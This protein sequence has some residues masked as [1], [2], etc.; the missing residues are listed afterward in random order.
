MSLVRFHS[1]HSPEASHLLR[2]AAVAA[3]VTGATVATVALVVNE[4]GKALERASD[5]N[6]TAIS[7]PLG[8]I[9]RDHMYDLKERLRGF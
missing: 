2:H 7:K 5:E 9:V 4:T 6:Y 3:G 1:T 8:Q